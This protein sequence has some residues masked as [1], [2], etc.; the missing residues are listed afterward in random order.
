MKKLYIVTAFAL[1]TVL[2]VGAGKQKFCAKCVVRPTVKMPVIYGPVPRPVVTPPAA[3]TTTSWYASYASKISQGG[4]E[5]SAKIKKDI[6]A[7]IAT[8]EKKLKNYR[9]QLKRLTDAG[10]PAEKVATL[11]KKIEAAQSERNTLKRML[12]CV[13]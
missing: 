8:T 5:S 12:S 13:K 9:A 11:R 1:C 6:E 7:S 10:A 2:S 3:P 4:T